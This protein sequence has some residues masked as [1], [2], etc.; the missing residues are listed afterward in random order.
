MDK[1]LFNLLRDR[2]VMV[3]KILLSNYKILNITDSE[4][5]LIM[6]IMSFGDKV[7]F[8]PEEYA[9]VINADKHEVM[10][11]INNLCKKNILS[12]DIEKSNRKTYEYLSLEPL[13]DKLFNI[14]I[15]N[16]EVDEIDVDSS[17]F[18]IFEN[19]LG[20]TLSPMEYEYIKEWIIS[21]ISNELI[22][23]ALREAVINGNG[24]LR[25]IGGILENWRKKGFKNKNDVLKDKEIYRSK[26]SKV[27]VFDTD[28]LNE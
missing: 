10:N 25:Y 14:I 1:N 20:R 11:T 16:D 2:P 22:I 19:E 18:Q 28:W 27:E 7:I 5:I 13:Y 15:D 4:L 17:V 8:N 3:P 24:S 6:V 12:L 9:R 23:C 26:K 21:G